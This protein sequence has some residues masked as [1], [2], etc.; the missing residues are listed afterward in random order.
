AVLPLFAFLLARAIWRWLI[1]SR[2]LFQLS[3]IK[4]RFAPTHPDR[5]GGLGFI[6]EPVAGA[7][8]VVFGI[9]TVIAATWHIEARLARVSIQVFAPSFL[10]LLA[11]SAVVT[12]G[13]LLFF[14]RAGYRAHLEATRE[15]SQLV[16]DYVQRVRGAWIEGR[17][18]GES[19]IGAF[20]SSSMADID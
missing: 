20:D 9:S 19:P 3:R 6:S 16:L 18:P 12:I 2:L 7:A 8:I 13:P 1:W 14:A 10:V 4:L 17:A 5:V 15:H 11:A